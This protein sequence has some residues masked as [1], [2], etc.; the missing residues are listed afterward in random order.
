VSIEF[1]SG[2]KKLRLISQPATSDRIRSLT[3]EK[4]TS[5]KLLWEQTTHQSST[6]NQFVN[7]SK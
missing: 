7:Q 1:S 3:W 2:G 6:I 4:Q 5:R